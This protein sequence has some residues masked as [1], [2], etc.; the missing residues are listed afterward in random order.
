MGERTGPNI[1]IWTGIDTLNYYGRKTYLS[2][3]MGIGT[4][5]LQLDN[6]VI[7]AGIFMEAPGIGPWSTTPGQPYV[8]LLYKRLNIG[9]STYT[10]TWELWTAPGAAG[11]TL[12][13]T[14][15]GVAGP[16]T[17]I[18]PGGQQTQRLE[19][20]YDPGVSVSAYIDGIL[21]VQHTTNLPT[22]TLIPSAQVLAGVGCWVENGQIADGARA[23]FHSL[24][25]E[26]YRP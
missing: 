3:Y 25:V 11:A 12:V 8:M 15:T 22:T 4:C 2:C 18:S 21:G 16:K 13:S 26:T 5:T 24:I 6:A 1:D 17:S 14:L 9:A 23:D 7:Y 20:I 10:E 19:I